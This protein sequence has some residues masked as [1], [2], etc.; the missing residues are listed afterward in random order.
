MKILPYINK[1]Q[2]SNTYKEF[3]QKYKDAFLVAGFFVIDFEEGKNLHQIDYYVPSKRKFAAFTLDK[4]VEF[5][6]MNSLDKRVPEHLDMETHIDLD[7]L[8]GIIQDEM[9]NRNITQSIK[10]MVAVIQNRE[11]KNI[12]NVNCILSGMDILK[13]HVE[14]VSKTILKMERSSVLD[15][16]KKL[17]ASMQPQ[18]PG[19]VAG[20]TG[21]ITGA[22]PAN[23][24]ELAK[25]IEQLDKL[26]D[27][28]KQEEIE[29]E[30]KGAGQEKNADKKAVKK[31]SKKK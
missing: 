26:K 3:Q 7:A 23:K 28:L 13:V 12:W 22:G 16:I 4:N 2:N 9:K 1:L 8:R 25:Q 31:T 19:Q 21:G 30:K 20:G 27:A 18:G 5:Q 17:P 24:E 11:G 14:D 15:Y 10:K 6:L 29:L